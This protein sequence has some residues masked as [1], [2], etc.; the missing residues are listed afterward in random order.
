MEPIVG[1]EPT[2]YY[3]YY[4]G[5]SSESVPCAVEHVHDDEDGFTVEIVII[6][7]GILFVDGYTDECDDTYCSIT[8][9]D[10]SPRFGVSS[11]CPAMVFR[12]GPESGTW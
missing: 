7:F 4:C 11:F 12:T 5:E 1:C 6:D 10:E 9:R 2:F 3:Y 8:H